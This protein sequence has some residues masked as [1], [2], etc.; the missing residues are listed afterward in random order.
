MEVGGEKE[1]FIGQDLHREGESDTEPSA[2]CE[3]KGEEE[4]EVTG[5]E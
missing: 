1:I 2:A 4:G 3:E 5:K